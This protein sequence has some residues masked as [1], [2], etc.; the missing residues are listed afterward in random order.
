[1]EIAPDALDDPQVQS[2]SLTPIFPDI[3]AI[4]HLLQSLSRIPE[5]LPESAVLEVPA[6]RVSV[7]SGN[8][9]LLP[10]LQDTLL[11]RPAVSSLFVPEA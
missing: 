5:A 4:R 1:M 6:A 7:V 9:P 3:S 11:L 10:L 2:W 8:V